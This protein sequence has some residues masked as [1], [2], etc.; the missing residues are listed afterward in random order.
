MPVD[1]RNRVQI[2]SVVLWVSPPSERDEE[3]RYFFFQDHHKE[4]HRSLG[5]KPLC[6]C[7]SILEARHARHN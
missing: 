6:P 3:R 2:R 1:V 4:A 5:A 7:F